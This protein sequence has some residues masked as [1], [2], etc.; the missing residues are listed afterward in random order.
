MASDPDSSFRPDDRLDRFRLERLLGR[1][2]FGQVWLAVD[3]GGFGFEKRVALKILD[4]MTNQQRVD[5]LIREAR[6]CAGLNHPNVID[7][8]G[9]GQVDKA[10]FIV[11][12]YVEG[13]TLAALWRDLDF[14]G[15]GFPRSIICDLGIAVAEALHHAWTANDTKGRPLAIVH[16]DL[17]PA[18]IMVSV[19]GVAKVG[20]FGVAKALPEPTDTVSGRLKGT[21]SYLAPEVW[22]G[23]RD[24]KPT[25]DLWSL[26]VIL[27]EL[28]VAKRFLGK[29]KV[30]QIFDLLNNRRPEDEA[31]E[32]E[33]HFPELAPIVKGLLQ[34]DPD[35]R[36]QTALEVA[37]A[38]R[39]I[40]Q[41]L[42]PGGDLLQ[43][44]R[45]VRAGRVEP[46]HRNDS[47][48]A[49]PALPKDAKDWLPLLKVAAEEYTGD[50]PAPPPTPAPPSSAS[51]KP[52]PP[53]PAPAPP[54]PRGPGPAQLAP[55]PVLPAPALNDAT[56]QLVDST[57]DEPMSTNSS[58]WLMA[59]GV[60]I[61]IGVLLWLLSLGD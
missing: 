58:V 39:S 13:E 8:Y 32:V 51:P 48:L 10:V 7:V 2:A 54:P 45:L 40:R 3:E 49:F 25:V 29:I 34:R 22:Q 27:W 43:F 41:G 26:G 1:G 33:K 52:Q 30:L 20:D 50:A 14:L 4:D 55:T 59:G 31:A 24:F 61:L 15:V 17:K 9:V 57:I 46:E 12:E 53:S 19:R 38:L 23:T 47:L 42:G 16:R 21:P 18:N 11:M 28:A 35:Q 44:M 60:L 37:D 6:I 56:E 36:F 5:S